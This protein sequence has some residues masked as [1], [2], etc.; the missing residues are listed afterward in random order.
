MPL[1]ASVAQDNL[2]PLA[3]T[4]PYISTINTA[5]T[6]WLISL[7]IYWLQNLLSRFY[8]FMFPHDST[9]LLYHVNLDTG[10]SSNRVESCIYDHVFAWRRKIC[11]IPSIFAM[12]TEG[13]PLCSIDQAPSH[14]PN[15]SF[16]E[17][18][19]P[20]LA[21][22]SSAWAVQAIT[23]INNLVTLIR[24]TGWILTS[25][26]HASGY[27]RHPCKGHQISQP[28]WNWC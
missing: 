26:E 14:Q 19:S 17:W 18:F 7:M 6:G 10:T 1:H 4:L 12:L 23:G 27:M 13:L 16:I 20:K 5:I 22:L 11:L 8:F 28:W 25:C 21:Y 15:F 9:I 24:W 2:R 3:G